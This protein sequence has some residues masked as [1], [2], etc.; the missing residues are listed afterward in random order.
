MIGAPE[1]L[2]EAASAI[3]L[4]AA[5]K[6]EVF[7]LIYSHDA[8]MLASP[9]RGME[10]VHISADRVGPRPDASRG[11]CIAG[12]S[13]KEFGIWVEVGLSGHV[14]TLAVYKELVDVVNFF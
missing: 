2:I 1:K 5:L 11:D 4:P 9:H 7:P 10:R 14:L 13:A 6:F 8:I 12:G 3:F